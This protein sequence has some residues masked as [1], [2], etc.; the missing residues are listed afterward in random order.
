MK[1]LFKIFRYL[2]GKCKECGNRSLK[3]LPFQKY[4]CL[5]CDSLF[6]INWWIFIIFSI[7]FLILSIII[8]IKIIN[9]IICILYF[10]GIKFI[11]KKFINWFLV[12]HHLIVNSTYE[13]TTKTTHS[14]Y[15]L[16]LSFD[17]C[18]V[19]IGLCLKKDYYE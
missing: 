18:G 8:K 11:P 4:Q 9:F 1:K 5:D 6:H 14:P 3:S 15:H 10:I 16:Y 2:N 7:I 13:I 12:N 19:G 17:G